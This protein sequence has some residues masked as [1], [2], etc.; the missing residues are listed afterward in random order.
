MWLL[1]KL[2][3]WCGGCE[4]DVGQ[5]FNLPVLAG[6]VENLPH[7]TPADTFFRQN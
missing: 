7:E 5:V 2:C 1:P 6:Q 4:R 3:M